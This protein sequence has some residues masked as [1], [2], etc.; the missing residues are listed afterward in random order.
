MLEA[1][2]QQ[3]NSHACKW[4][5]DLNTTGIPTHYWVGS[6]D[7][8]DHLIVVQASTFAFWAECDV[9]GGNLMV[10]HNGHTCTLWDLY[11]PC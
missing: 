5:L 4:P 8:E 9:A 7:A 11:S 3:F 10:V 1:T 6:K 2:G